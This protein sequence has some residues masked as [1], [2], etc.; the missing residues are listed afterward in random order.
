M[1]TVRPEKVIEI[2]KANN[3]HISLEEAALILAFMFKFA[4][5]ALTK[6]S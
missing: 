2:L 5:I 1:E 4:R 6:I 3:V